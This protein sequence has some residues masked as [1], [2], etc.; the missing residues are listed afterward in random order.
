MRLITVLLLVFC[1]S[2][3]AQDATAAKKVR[4]TLE[5]MIGISFG[6]NLVAI[7]VG[8]P[9][10]KAKIGKLGIGVC[11]MPSLFIHDGKPEPKLGV[12]FRVD[13]GRLVFLVPGYYISNQSKWL[14]SYGIGYKF[15]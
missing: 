9:T 15:H 5:G 13:Y 8:G 3:H 14:W 2:A 11:A 7:N 1:T 12:G 10:L 4:I 6:N